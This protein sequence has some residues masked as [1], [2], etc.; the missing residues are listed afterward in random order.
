MAAAPAR[1]APHDAEILEL[2]RAGAL[3]RAFVLLLD[4]YE[5]KM[6]RLCCA[7]L[8]DHALAQDVAQESLL[9]IW[10]AL[11]RYDGRAALSTWIY[12]IARN[13]CRTA[14]VRRRAQGT[15]EDV[16]CLEEDTQP[17]A[18]SSDGEQRLE[19]LREL[20]NELPERYRVAIT[21][22]YYEGRSVSEVAVLL[23]MPE[24]T[25]KTRLHRARAA[26]LE[27]LRRRGFETLGAYME[28]SP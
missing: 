24:G 21:L 6:Y 7:V 17:P 19:L 1:A 10:R 2:L 15:R 23:A 20:V 13:R 5:S 11:G 16:D 27:Q 14:L 8:G 4:R 28:N 25:V 9:R 22:Y 12:T 26:L 3:E 18:A